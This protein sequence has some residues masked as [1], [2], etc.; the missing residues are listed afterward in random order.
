M[1]TL[2]ETLISELGMVMSSDV[3][4]TVVDMR[5]AVKVSGKIS[6]LD[7][8]GV[9]TIENIDTDENELAIT[10]S[11]VDGASREVK[12]I[13]VIVGTGVNAENTSLEAGNELKMASVDVKNAPTEVELMAGDDGVEDDV[14]VLTERVSSYDDIS[15]SLLLKYVCKVLLESMVLLDASI[16]DGGIKTD[17]ST[18]VGMKVSFGALIEVSCEYKSVVISGMKMFEEGTVNV[19]GLRERLVGWKIVLEGR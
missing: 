5:E 7:G 15:M 8:R 9:V 11:E 19:E 18:E 14:I 6:L 16:V 3:S 17:A 1:K 2:R 13:L 12:C 10:S 4:N